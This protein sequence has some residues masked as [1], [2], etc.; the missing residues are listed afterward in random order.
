MFDWIL[1]RIADIVYP[2]LKSRLKDQIELVLG[3]T[4][5]E[6][7]RISSN[8]EECRNDLKRLEDR[9]TNL[10]RKFDSH[11][12]SMNQMQD[13]IRGEVNETS[14]EQRRSIELVRKQVEQV[15]SDQRTIND[16]FSDKFQNVSTVLGRVDANLNNLLKDDKELLISLNLML[17]KANSTFPQFFRETAALAED[18]KKVIALLEKL[19]GD[20][21]LE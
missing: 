3:P 13:K 20:S 1:E 2:K 4:L 7:T 16:K 9:L 17:I 21:L 6:L 19:D 12:P 18:R 8:V 14:K 5:T 15:V 10:E 11:G